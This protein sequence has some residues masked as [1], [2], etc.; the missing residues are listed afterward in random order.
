[1]FLRWQKAAETTLLTCFWQSDLGLSP[2]NQFGV[3]ESQ[4]VPCDE[5]Q[6]ASCIMAANIYEIYIIKY[7]S[8]GESL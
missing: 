1:M 6:I 7:D 2:Q 5:R 8:F 3:Q 4:W